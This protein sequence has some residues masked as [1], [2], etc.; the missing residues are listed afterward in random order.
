MGS[1]LER[2]YDGSSGTPLPSP[3]PATTAAHVLVVDRE[4]HV[5][6]LLAVALGHVGFSVEKADSVQAARHAMD[7][8]TPDALILDVALPDGDGIE[9]C[10]RL[11]EAGGREPVLFLTARDTTAEKVRALGAGGDDYVTKPFVLEELI[12]RLRAVLR[13]AAGEAR[14]TMRLRYD[15]LEL[16]DD[17]REARRGDRLVALTPTEFK[18]LRLLLVNADHV[19]S[20]P[21]ILEQVWQYDFGGDYNVVETYISYLR[22]KVDCSGRPLIRTIRGSGYMLRRSS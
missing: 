5:T 16:Y 17:T 2:E 12:A 7:Q 6:G 9:L 14:P 13:R 3:S 8:R 22:K 15:D 19:V 18:L 4:P 10:E 11:R 20:K 21:A 1:L